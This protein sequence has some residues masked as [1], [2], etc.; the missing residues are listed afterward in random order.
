MDF[1]K[2]LSA[3]QKI[4]ILKNVKIFTMD[5]ALDN[6]PSCV[7]TE[8]VNMYTIELVRVFAA[9]SSTPLVSK[10]N[11]L[12]FP[13]THSGLIPGLEQAQVKLRDEL[14]GSYEEEAL[15]VRGLSTAC[16]MLPD[17]ASCTTRLLCITCSAMVEFGRTDPWYCA[18]RVMV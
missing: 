7:C 5:A 16:V 18:K 17:C 6:L 15:S 13:S 12:P 9:I 2:K 11:A 14:S 3:A 4:C 1:A 8:T 10:A